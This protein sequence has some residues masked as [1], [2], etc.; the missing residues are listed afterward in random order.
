MI[1]KLTWLYQSRELKLVSL[2]RY[3]D[4]KKRRGRIRK[5][6]GQVSVACLIDR[7]PSKTLTL[8]L[9]I[10]SHVDFMQWIRQLIY[11]RHI[12]ALVAFCKFKIWIWPSLFSQPWKEPEVRYTHQ[13]KTLQEQMAAR[14]IFN[15]SIMQPPSNSILQNPINRCNYIPSSKSQV[16]VSI[17]LVSL[18]GSVC[19]N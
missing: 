16:F 1:W 13:D 11:F 19:L 6:N 3:Q 12:S 17:N 8:C 7:H 18:G 9:F 14:K 2:P 15:L 10:G 4:M 5:W